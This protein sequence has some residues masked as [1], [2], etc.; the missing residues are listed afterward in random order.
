MNS[1]TLIIVGALIVTACAV[2]GFLRRADAPERDPRAGFFSHTGRRYDAMDT[3][4]DGVGGG[5]RPAPRLHSIDGG[6]K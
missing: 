1:A 2:V 3:G 6:R 4:A 5:E